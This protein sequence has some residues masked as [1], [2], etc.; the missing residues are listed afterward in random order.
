MESSSLAH[1]PLTYRFL[2]DFTAPCSAFQIL[3]GLQ[4][5]GDLSDPASEGNPRVNLNASSSENNFH[6][7]HTLSQIP[8]PISLSIVA[9]R[10]PV[11]GFV[12]VTGTYTRL[13]PPGGG[14]GVIWSV[15]KDSTTLES[16]L[17]LNGSASFSLRKVQVNEDD[18]LYFTLDP[19]GD[20]RSDTTAL[21]VTITRSGAP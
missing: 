12:N 5:W 6:P 7:P 9:W 17:L 3:I 15:D 19:N 8:G 21:E 16:A 11:H 1:D 20:F 18:V 10:S 13:E 4:C 2:P 14:N